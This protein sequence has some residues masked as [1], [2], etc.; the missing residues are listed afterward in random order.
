MLSCLAILAILAAPS[1]TEQLLE[2][3]NKRLASEK[4]ALEGKVRELE[5][6]VEE[7]EVRNAALTE[8]AERLAKDLA[9]WRKK[10][11]EQVLAGRQA[12]QHRLASEEAAKARKAE[13]AKRTYVFR[14]GGV[15]L[16]LGPIRWSLARSVEGM[17]LKSPE[18]YQW[19]ELQI[20][21]KDLKKDWLRVPLSAIR[22]ISD[23]QAIAPVHPA[24]VDRHR[25]YM[26]DAWS[27]LNSAEQMLFEGIEV[28]PGGT[29][30]L[31]LLLPR[32]LDLSAAQE[33]TCFTKGSALSFL[34]E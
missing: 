27:R 34:R 17:L 26:T 19:I 12:E 22:I 4:A 33:I 16:M 9:A 13:A 5:L 30:R 21:A 32:T 15:R 29:G 11:K 20:D 1:L 25:T 24:S 23:G 8:K 10:L 3:S 31:Y 28:P 6:K 2:K 18:D 14:A 7:L